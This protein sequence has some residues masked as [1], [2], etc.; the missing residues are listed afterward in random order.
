MTKYN[1]LW[2]LKKLNQGVS[3]AEIGSLLGITRQAM[4]QYAKR[5]FVLDKKWILK[6]RKAHEPKKS[7]IEG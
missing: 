5:K 7:S 1:N 3:L 2:I 4:S 6:E